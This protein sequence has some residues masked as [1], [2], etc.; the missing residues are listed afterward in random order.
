[1]GWGVS[2]HTVSLYFN[3]LWITRGKRYQNILQ[4]NILTHPELQVGKVGMPIC[5]LS[6]YF[7][8]PWT[9]GGGGVFQIYCK[10]IL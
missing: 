10:F 1:M 2:K 7:N 4:L 6:L 9:T 5:I 8:V 3:V